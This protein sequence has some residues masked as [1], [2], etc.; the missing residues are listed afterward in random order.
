MV[1]LV[2]RRRAAR[3]RGRLARSSQTPARSAPAPAATRVP[4]HAAHA[5]P[6]RTRR[7]HVALL[8]LCTRQAADDDE[9]DA[10]VANDPMDADYDGGAEDQGVEA[11]E[12]LFE[13]ENEEGVELGQ[14]EA[15][16]RAALAEAGSRH[17]TRR[18]VERSAPFQN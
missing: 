15:A 12:N 13:D 8:S 11:D 14:E 17:L 16:R 10:E 7:A 6:A 5:L 18:N 4:P 9:V 2:R 1:R 3:C